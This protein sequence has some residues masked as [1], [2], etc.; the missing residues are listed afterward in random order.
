MKK[1]ILAFAAMMLTATVSAQEKEMVNPEQKQLDKIE[2]AKRRT[3]ETVKKLGLNDEQAAQLLELNTKYA[4][5]MG[6]GM[7]GKRFGRQ[8]ERRQLDGQ[9]PMKHRPDSLAKK[10]D[11]PERPMMKNPEEMHATREAYDAELKTI[12]TE[13]Q[14]NAYKADMQ[15]R[16]GHGPR[17]G[18]RPNE[19]VK[20]EKVNSE[21][22]KSEK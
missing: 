13:E 21:K 2:M 5:K 8:G 1:M 12:L 3:D 19:K 18:L 7:R 20:N 15:K 16:M 10:G 17:G 11:R 9:A 6:P 4:E 22:V 14:Y